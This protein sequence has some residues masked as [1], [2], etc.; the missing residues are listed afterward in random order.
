VEIAIRVFNYVWFST[1]GYEEHVKAESQLAIDNLLRAGRK[2]QREIARSIHDL[3]PRAA[4][5][6]R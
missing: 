6:L 3:D 2:L 4:L 1:F 5:I